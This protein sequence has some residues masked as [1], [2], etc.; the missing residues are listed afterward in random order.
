MAGVCRQAAALLGNTPVVCR[1]NYIDP[2]VIDH[3][4]DGRTIS[5]LR[6]EVERRL[7]RGRSR[8][9]V[10]VLVLLRRGLEERPPPDPQTPARSRRRADRAAWYPHIPWTPPP[11]GVDEEQR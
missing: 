7:E 9:E 8:E 1:V 5:S 3:F 11:G 4:L 6:A 10:A 2:R